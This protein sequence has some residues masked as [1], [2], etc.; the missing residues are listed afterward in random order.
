VKP[1]KGKVTFS[2]GFWTV[3]TANGIEIGSCPGE[4]RFASALAAVALAAE[5]AI[6][7]RPEGDREEYEWTVV[8]IEVSP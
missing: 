8:P 5:G 2:A 7:V 3:R 4:P 1:M 6:E